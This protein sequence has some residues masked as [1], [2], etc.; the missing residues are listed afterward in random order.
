MKYTRN[1]NNEVIEV[2]GCTT[3][4]HMEKRTEVDRNGA[5][6]QIMFCRVP[7]LCASDKYKPRNKKLVNNWTGGYHASCPL[8][9]FAEAVPKL[10]EVEK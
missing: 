2:K 4:P 8:A 3:C 7:V 9:S 5:P 1:E 10:P 6:V